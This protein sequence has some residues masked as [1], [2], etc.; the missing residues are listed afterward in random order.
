ML[1][2][3]SIFISFKATENYQK[4]KKHTHEILEAFFER[5]RDL[6]DLLLDLA[7]CVVGDDKIQQIYEDEC[8]EDYDDDLQIRYKTNNLDPAVSDI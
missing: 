1:Q 5:E 8:N 3:F 4:T 6:N 2:F 7:E